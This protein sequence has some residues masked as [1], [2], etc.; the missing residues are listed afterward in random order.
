MRLLRARGLIIV[1]RNFFFRGG[2]LDIVAREADCLVFCE[3]RTRA[4][5]RFGGAAESVTRQKQ[6][7][8]ELAAR[9]FIAA[10]PEFAEWPCRFD[11]LA[12][13]GDADWQWIRDAFA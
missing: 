3:V 1:T 4:D 9:A 10:R 2:E 7:R 6:R 12:R 13:D 5:L 8:L 11:V